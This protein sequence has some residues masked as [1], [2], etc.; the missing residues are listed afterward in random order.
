MVRLGLQRHARLRHTGEH[1]GGA[2]ADAVRPGDVGVDP[3]PDH[4]HAL[5]ADALGG[6]LHHRQLGLA[7][8]DGLAPGCRLDGRQHGPGPRVEPGGRREDVVAVGGD[9]DRPIADRVGRR[10][11][12]VVR[13]VGVA[14]DHDDVHLG[15][16]L[17][18]DHIEE[19]GDLLHHRRGAHDEGPLAFEALP[20]DPG[21][22]RRGGG[23]DLLLL[24]LDPTG[25][26]VL[27]DP[28]R[29]VGGVVG[30]EEHRL[31]G[32]PD[33]L[34]GLGS[35]GDDLAAQ[36]DDAVEVE[37]ERAVALQQRGPHR[38][39]LLAREALQ[40]A[41]VVFGVGA[42]RHR[43]AQVPDGAGPVARRRLAQA[44]A[45]VGV[46]VGGVQLEHPG[47]LLPGSPLLP[48]LV[49]GAGEGLADRGLLRLQLA[50]A[51]EHRGGL[52]GV[53]LAQK[54]AAPAEHGVDVM[55]IHEPCL[56]SVAGLHGIQPGVAVLQPFRA[57]RFAPR[58]DL[59]L[60]TSPPYD[61][62]SEAVRARLLETDPHNIVRII[63]PGTEAG[64]ASEGDRFGRAAG[65][66]R[67]WLGSGILVG[68]PSAAHYAYRMD[69][70]VGGASRATGGVIG[71]LVLEDPGDG[72]FVHEH[73]MPKPRSE[74]KELYRAARANL[75]PIW[76][77][78]GDGI[79]GPMV[80]GAADREPLADITD[81]AG[82]RHRAWALAPE[83]SW[84]L[85]EGVGTSLV[86]A[87]GHHRFAA[88]L[89]LR[90]ELRAAEGPGPWDATLALVSDPTDEP[91]SLLP[92]H[93][94]TDLTLAE[95]ASAGIL[96]PFPGSVEALSEHL[97][98]GGPGA[99][100]VATAE[101]RWT[102]AIDPPSL[103][104]PDT[105]WVARHLL[106]GVGR[107]VEVVYEHDLEAVVAGVA[108]GRL[109]ILLA[110][111]PV[112]TVIETALAGMVMPPK[113]TLFWPKPRTGIVMRDFERP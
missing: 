92:I 100:G 22:G 96:V 89:A 59:A 102:M 65:A 36:P 56:P 101:G 109:A 74:R 61:V 32:V 12:A 73:T 80:A 39:R 20:L 23:E 4:Q 35:L 70:Q 62:I 68:D 15:P 50:G 10:G 82:V 91:P 17:D 25:A 75:E 14:G 58:I 31:A 63:L 19:V 2:P 95:V 28:E 72:I 93:R 5:D 86:I 60:V 34:D 57:V 48:A 7:Q 83:E 110:P 40:G 69:Y 108:G 51:L 46:V 112:R 107:S 6:G 66:F 55:R 42:H 78:G 26:E 76:L 43:Q 37:G 45:E 24:Y 47:E 104:A 16:P 33:G 79:I 77:T 9:E 44:E 87:D 67:E 105:S 30:E 3:V 106:E 49:E 41:P 99:I 90:D 8:A 103:G 38:C 29:D 18:G 113:S 111:I 85:A 11:E 64:D 13:E 88:S 1:H 21:P 97:A 52:V 54:V 27:H 98:T 53:A 81:P 71:A 94:L 84:A